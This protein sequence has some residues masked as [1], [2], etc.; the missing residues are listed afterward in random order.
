MTVFSHGKRDSFY[1]FEFTHAVCMFIVQQNEFIISSV[2]MYCTCRWMPL[3]LQELDG[4]KKKSGLL[5][6]NSFLKLKSEYSS[7]HL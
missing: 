5:A 3:D 4:V 1:L 2:I 7:A 6:E